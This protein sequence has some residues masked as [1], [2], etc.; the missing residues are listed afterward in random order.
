MTEYKKEQVVAEVEDTKITEGDVDALMHAM[1]EQARQFVGETGR[2]RLR[3]E[4]V[5]QELL[6]R[7][8]LDCH[9]DEEP[10]FVEQL[11]GMKRQMLQQYALH[12]VL[13]SVSVEREEVEKYYE[14]RKAHLKNGYEFHAH[15]I[16]VPSEEKAQELKKEIQEGASFEEVAK[17]HSTC[18]SSARGGDLGTFREGMMVPEFEE[19]CKTLAVGEVSEPVKTQFGYHL[20]RLNERKGGDTPSLEQAYPQLEK[21]LRLMK[22]QEFYREKISALSQNYKVVK[23]YGQ[24]NE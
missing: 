12:R 10:E 6:Y 4:L 15:H 20:V 14:Q 18:P 5:N 19:A 17:K 8:A 1:G 7:E 24:D 11:E 13:N 9:F 3:D 23:H 21:E 16:L 22:Q 2:N